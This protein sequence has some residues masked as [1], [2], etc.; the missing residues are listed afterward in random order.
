MY[1]RGNP[2]EPGYEKGPDMPTLVPTLTETERN[3]M[4]N[5]IIPNR[6]GIPG[7]VFE[8]A[9]LHARQR[10]AMGLSPFFDSNT[11]SRNRR[12]RRSFDFK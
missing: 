10:Q 12:Q 6:K 2:G 11:E 8:K 7:P 4:V 3:A 5:D 9:L 1:E